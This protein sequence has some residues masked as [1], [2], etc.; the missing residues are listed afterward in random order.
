MLCLLVVLKLMLCALLSDRDT[1]DSLCREL[2]QHLRFCLQSTPMNVSQLQSLWF[3]LSSDRV[4][5]ETL[6]PQYYA[7]PKHLTRLKDLKKNRRCAFLVLTVVLSTFQP[8]EELPFAW[9]DVL[10]EALAA[11]WNSSVTSDPERW[12]KWDPLC[13]EGQ[14][15]SK[16]PLGPDNMVV[17]LPL[18]FIN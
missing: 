12:L 15:S 6:Y 11:L 14:V 16:S 10:S 1:E 17:L 18:D 5:E 9:C 7:C 8:A 3:L 13:P 4:S 2:S